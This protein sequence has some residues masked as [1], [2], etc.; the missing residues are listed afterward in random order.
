MTD[1]DIGRAI[2]A[3]RHQERAEAI[4]VAEG[5]TFALAVQAGTRADLREAR[6][7]LKAAIVHALGEEF[8]RGPGSHR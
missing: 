6:S 3:A 7:L 1:H 8:N 4:V 2:V 5:L